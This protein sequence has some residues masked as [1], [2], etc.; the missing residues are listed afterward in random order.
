VDKKLSR[1]QQCSLPKRK[2]NSLLGCFRQS[3]ASRSREVI[4]LRYPASEVLGP[5]LGSPVQGR[6]ELL[7]A[8]PAQGH[9][10]D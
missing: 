4:Y 8:S 1:M 5:F 9:K 2:T 7:G 6:H 10:D 3:V